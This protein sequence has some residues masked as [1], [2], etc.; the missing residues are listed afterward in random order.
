MMML[1]TLCSLYSGYG[2]EGLSA[3]SNVYPGY[4][5]SF[6]GAFVGMFYTFMHGFLSLYFAAHLYNKFTKEWTT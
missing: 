2:W 1:L 3:I 4:T 6:S 5:V